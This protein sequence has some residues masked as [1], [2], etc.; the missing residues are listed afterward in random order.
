MNKI[1]I[2]NETF[3]ILYLR[4]K[5]EINPYINGKNIA[6]CLASKE[7]FTIKKMKIIKKMLIDL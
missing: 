7:V 4:S 6:M 5:V 3:F 1:T 2:K